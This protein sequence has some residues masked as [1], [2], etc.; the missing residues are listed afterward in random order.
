MLRTLFMRRVAGRNSHLNTAHTELMPPKLDQIKHSAE[1][2]LK[3][4]YALPLIFVLA[5]ALLWVSEKTHR[6]TTTSLRGGIEL[7]DARVKSLRLLQLLTETE[8]AEFAYLV[9]GQTVHLARYATVK[10]ELKAALSEVTAFFAAQGPVGEAAAMR[11]ADFTHLKL[12]HIDRTLELARNGNLAAALEMAKD[13]RDRATGDALRTELNTQLTHAA[14]RQE[15][16]RTS[17]YDALDLNRA[18]VGLLTLSSLLSLIWLVRQLNRQDRDRAAQQ[19]ALLQERERLETEVRRRTAR[20]T[21]LAKHLQSVREHERAHLARELHDELGALLTASKLEIARARAKKTNPNEMSLGLERINSYLNE[22]IALKRRIIEDLRPSALSTLGLSAALENLCRD[23]SER[24]NVPVQLSA[25]DFTLSADADLAVYRFV[26][27]A[28]TNIGKHAHANEVVVSLK[29]V[30]NDAT[31]EVTD[32]GVGFVPQDTYLGQHGL[33]GMRF[34][35]ESLGGSMQVL[36]TPGQ[37]CLVRIEFAQLLPRP[38]T[39][40]DSTLN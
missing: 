19:G 26:Q 39:A 10:S 8:A 7:T 28:L 32:N 16:A 14:Q 29:V 27:E 21:E 5:A 3:T 35:A 20:L 4:R 13:E 11:V 2:W 31:V 38:K 23:M 18:A 33:S 9:G 12:D 24:L 6:D 36:S 15:S 22:G 30:G 37:G 40:E 34:R 25:V 17:I 1:R